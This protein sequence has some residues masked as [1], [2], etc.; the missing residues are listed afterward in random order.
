MR[1]KPD[2]NVDDMYLVLHHH[3]AI[4][5]T[6]YPDERQR[7]QLAL[8]ILL[9]SYTASRPGALVYNPS[10]N[11]LRPGADDG[12]WAPETQEIVKALCWQDITLVLLPNPSG[13]RD[14]LAA[15]VNLRHTKGSDKNPSE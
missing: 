5:T 12:L 10:N 13:T 9:T 4:D 14:I 2:M 15:E 1:E 11:R 6:S 7:L 8:L 3:W